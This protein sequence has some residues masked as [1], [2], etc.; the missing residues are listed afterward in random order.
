MSQ[1]SDSRWKAHHFFYHGDLDL[2]LKYFV[3]PAVSELIA[4]HLIDSF[5]FIRYTLGGPHIRL[6]YRLKLGG[7]SVAAARILE[8]AA[9]RFVEH[10]PSETVLDPEEIRRG[11]R[12]ILAIVPEES[13]LYYENYSLLPFLFEPEVNR[14]GG[15]E[16]LEA[17]LDFFAISSAQA[18]EMVHDASWGSTGRRGAMVLRVLLRQAW[19]FAAS[20]QE[21][22]SHLGYRLP[23]D[24]EVANL[25]WRKADSDFDERQEGYRALL[26]HELSLLSEAVS[27]TEEPVWPSTLFLSEAAKRLSQEV[28]NAVPGIRWQIGHSQLHMMANR[29]GF[30]PIQEMHL[31]RILWRAA[32]GLREAIPEIWR[33]VVIASFDREKAPRS[34]LRQL[35]ESVISHLQ[36]LNDSS[37]HE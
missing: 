25:I 30:F 18:L 13:E 31:Q 15:Q 9:A 2:A 35:L 11:S 14:Y 23:V 20:E 34:S 5:F 19:G 10:W 26:K 29:L 37:N 4:H 8:E 12:S 21:F 22:L 24:Q 16:F 27:A 28:R 6:R 36:K 1:T 17:S 3:R 7:S 33:N 32:L